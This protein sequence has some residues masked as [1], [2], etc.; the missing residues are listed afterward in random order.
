MKHFLAGSRPTPVSGE[1]LRR[2]RPRNGTSIALNKPDAV[3]VH[4]SMFFASRTNLAP[5][6]VFAQNPT[7]LDT[8]KKIF[9]LAALFVPFILASPT[10]AADA[11]ANW[12]K[13]CVKCHSK[14]GKGN[15]KMGRQAGV[16]DYTDAKVQAEMKD[17][18]ALKTIK[19]G[20]TENG[21]EKMKAY[22]GDLTDDEIKAL[23]AYMR[24]FKK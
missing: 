21:K 14:D 1:T 4:R 10:M 11:Q 9:L 18:K 3:A 13:H 8:M 23:I 24:A 22:A 2:D 16:K 5:Q 19:E 6:H 7:N 15:T 17:D 12:T 20:I